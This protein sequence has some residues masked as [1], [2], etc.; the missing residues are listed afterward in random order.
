MTDIKVPDAQDQPTGWHDRRRSLRGAMGLS[1]VAI[2]ALVSIGSVANAL[3]TAPSASV[4]MARTAADDGAVFR[5]S[6]SRA[7]A[8]SAILRTEWLQPSTTHWRI[9]GDGET[10]IHAG[11][12]YFALDGPTGYLREGSDAFLGY[13]RAKPLAMGPLLKHLSGGGVASV[14]DGRT[15]LRFTR[16]G[17]DF[18]ATIQEHILLARAA[19][20]FVV[21][22]SRITTTQRELRAGQ[23]TSL[24]VRAYWLG[25]QAAGRTAITAMEYR[26]RVTDARHAAGSSARDEATLH[27]TF[28]EEPAARGMNSSM[29]GETAPAGEIQVSSQPIDL[30][31]AQGAIDAINGKNG[32]LRY[33]PWPR[34][35]VTLA[36]G[37][38]ATLVLDRGESNGDTRLAFLVLTKP[39]FIKVTGVFAE[40]EIPGLAS[41]LRPLS[42]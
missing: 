33:E 7:D 15:Q 3:S 16:A 5:V 11:N 31:A 17:V 29:P 39:T 4:A 10:K 23:A 35:T 32:D 25:R 26:N 42:G 21:P 19:D 34:T 9:E 18:I 8:P 41:Q 28:Y 12:R 6:L 22:Q 24:P 20:L 37:E 2:A 38:A 40:A 13:L 27:I 36:N 30:P 1:L 14:S